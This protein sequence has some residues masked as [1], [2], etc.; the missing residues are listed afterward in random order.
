MTHTVKFTPE[1]LR[2]SS[3]ES[4]FHHQEKRSK[5]E[6]LGVEVGGKSRA[7]EADK[8]RGKPTIPVTILSMK[9]FRPFSKDI[10][11]P[12][13]L[14]VKWLSEYSKY[15]IINIFYSTFSQ[16]TKKRFSGFFVPWL[17]GFKGGQLPYCETYGRAV[18]MLL[19]LMLLA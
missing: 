15:Y 19:A 16:G 1:P 8:R 10:I 17:Q 6:L 11:L 9:F 4:A 12:V 7:K 14:S 2:I 3:P 5:K 18:S 13:S